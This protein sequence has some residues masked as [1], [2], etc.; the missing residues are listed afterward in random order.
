MPLPVPRT[1]S[2]LSLA[3]AGALTF[4]LLAVAPASAEEGPAPSSAAPASPSDGELT[5][6]SAIVVTADSAE[7][8]TREVPAEDVAAVTAELNAQPGVVDVSVDTPVEI[9]GTDDLYRYEQWAL[10]DLGLDSLPVNAPDGS[11]QLVAV[12]DTGVLAAHEDLQGRVRCDLGADFASDA[13]TVDPAGTGCV[14]PDG[15]GTHVAGQI[16]A[17][18]GNGLGIAGASAAE[19]MPVR[20]LNASGQGTSASVASGIF[21][22]VDHGADVINMSLAGPYNSKYDTAVRYAV[23]RGVVVVAAAGNNRDEGNLVNYPA[24]SPGAIAVA[25]TDQMRESAYFSYSGPTNLIAAPGWSVLSTDPW[26]DYTYRSGT[27]MAAPHV[28]AVL[29]RYRQAHPTA[30]PADVRAAVVATAID[31][32]VPGFDDNTG[33]GLIDGY[34]LLTGQEAPPAAGAPTAPAGISTVP[35]DRRVEVSWS[36]ADPNGSPVTGYTVTATPGGATVRTDGATTATLTGLTNG[37]TYTVEVTA[38]NAVGTGPAAASGT[39]VPRAASPIDQAWAFHGGPSGLLGDVAGTEVC[40]LRDA[41]CFRAFQR[42]SIYWSVGTG[43]RV[44]LAG[45][46]ADRW[47]RAGWENG[48]LGWP[49]SDTTC[50]LPASGCFQQFQG[51]S[52]Y[53][54]SGSPATVVTGALRDRWSAAGWER[55]PLGYPTA[56]QVCGLRDGGCFQRFQHGALYGSNATGARLVLAG[57]V[58]DRWARAGWENGV[59]GYP[60]A[61]QVCG[62]PAGGCF[63]QFQGGSVYASSG[64]PATVVTG[65]LRDRWGAAGWE[66]GPLGYPTADQVC[67]L[68]D[69][70][71]FQR[72]QHGSVYRSNATAARVV[73]D[74]AVRDRWGATGWENGVLGY[75]TAEQVCGLPA[76]GC[77]QHFQ[78]GSVYVSSGSPAT[79]VT[80]VLRDRWGASGWERGPLGYPTAAQV[81]GLRAGG[82]FQQFQGGSVYWSPATGA[83]PV[84]GDLRTRWGQLGW[85]NGQLGYPVAGVVVLSNGDTSQ[86]FQGGTLHRT[87]GTGVVRVL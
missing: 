57:P 54:S 14:D 51:G 59:L 37:T 65:A 46:V 69:G 16:S 56:D 78:G 80:G 55:G 30:T 40:G 74:G 48:A 77:F 4:P 67:G 52:V 31:L 33:Y 70:G 68:R 76:G 21:H 43:A 20:V 58:A 73:L 10:A 23:D 62:L 66:R 3:L 61:D 72:F 27:S 60:T 28:A 8:V 29:A 81:C 2:L 87:A 84:Q 82:C 85:E 36:A 25:A 38:T 13:A 83:H 32:E 71:C 50:G 7:V 41:G 6:V 44:V 22:A 79:V 15:H 53:V 11:D 39:F 5:A 49:V 19:V 63:Q 64:S 9:A 17:V 86:R 34:E 24:A 12:L 18:S 42:G 47:A 35:G 1:R 26:Y 45:A 75:P